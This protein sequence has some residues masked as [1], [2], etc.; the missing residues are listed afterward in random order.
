MFSDRKVLALVVAAIGLFWLLFQAITPKFL[1]K[2][3][4]EQS[5]T[6]I[7]TSAGGELRFSGSELKAF[8]S[9][10]LVVKDAEL[11]LPQYG[12]Q[13]K[14]EKIGVGLTFPSFWRGRTLPSFVKV[15]GGNWNQKLS[16]ASKEME[17]KN[18]YFRLG[19]I[20]YSQF[21]HYELRGDVE[22]SPRSLSIKGRAR[23]PRHG[24]ASFKNLTLNGSAQI[25]GLALKPFENYFGE[26][27]AW[28]VEK[29]AARGT[30]KFNKKTGENTVAFDMKSQVENL[31]YEMEEGGNHF[32]S[33]E[34][35]TDILVDLLWD[36]ATGEM[37]FR[38]GSAGFPFGLAQMRGSYFTGARN[39]KG[40][41][42]SFLDFSLDGVSMYY[43]PLSGAIPFNFGFSGPSHAEISLEGTMDRMTVHGDWDMTG[44]LLSY[45][46]YFSKSKETPASF[47]FDFV[48]SDRQ[49]LAGNFSLLLKD[50]VIKGALPK[51]NLATGEGELNVISNKF[52]I[53]GWEKMLI[54][55]E[56]CLL[57][58]EVKLLANYQG[59]ILRKP[60]EAKTMLNLTLDNVS[61]GRPDGWE[62]KNISLNLDFAPVSFEIRQFSFEL[63][64]SVIGG[65]VTAFHPLKDPQIEVKINSPSVN[66][67]D[68]S[69]VL[70]K[71]A[72]HAHVDEAASKRFDYA[73]QS[74]LFFLGADDVKNLFMDLTYD[75]GAWTVK[76]MQA[77]VLGGDFKA[78]GDYQAA[79]QN[80]KFDAQV[81]HLDVSRLGFQ[82]T[83]PRPLVEGNLFL[84]FQGNGQVTDDN[85]QSKLAGQG[86]FS[87]TAGA[88]SQVDLLGGMSG[89]PELKPLAQYAS[90]QTRFDDL[91]SSFSVENGKI[92][93][94]K[95]DLIGA[96]VNAKADGSI[97][98]SDGAFNYRLD[99]FLSQVLS[100]NLLE[101]LG[102]PAPA[103]PDKKQL[104]PIPFLLAGDFENLDL[105]SDPK[106][107]SQFQ[108]DL[109]KKKTYKVF[110]SFLPE[111]FLLKRP[112]SS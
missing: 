64:K 111:D 12:F 10:A 5:L 8:P 11:N 36:F 53:S 46:K 63:G 109:Q 107:V 112:S 24:G 80:Y 4:L 32:R 17:I 19:H 23:M 71:L 97:S 70:K 27:R 66:F 81:D 34:I 83:R 44:M 87:V 61:A 72:R 89:I 6:R 91:R 7:V 67:L 31:I 103:G 45:A 33:P 37:A 105:K 14:A 85:W 47:A 90:G 40:M 78:K 9:L 21:M 43:P 92:L 75:A 74:I 42:L 65:S 94:S 2:T 54:P 15:E 49:G 88:L 18:L 77:Q 110:S 108:E 20:T 99:A 16:G 59:N 56:N 62:I 26:T 57:A 79:A 13:L 95:V 104:G 69:A 39:F 82:K 22:G 96:D 25:K 76:D 102:V 1:N 106:R 98:L 52:S 60:G 86:I 35:K 28:L 84:T 3:S 58:G 68:L 93:T 30:V 100:E 29:G 51:L 41:H 101:T 55:F 38:R 73:S 48:I 50:A